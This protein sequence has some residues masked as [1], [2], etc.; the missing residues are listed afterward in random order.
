[1][2]EPISDRKGHIECVKTSQISP[3]SKI[4]YAQFL[5][6]AFCSQ[7]GGFCFAF[8]I[9]LLVKMRLLNVLFCLIIEYFV[10][11][12]IFFSDIGALSKFWATIET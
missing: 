12:L 1:M 5:T 3:N 4:P 10:V 9:G 2:I 6:G 8:K 7:W 11:P